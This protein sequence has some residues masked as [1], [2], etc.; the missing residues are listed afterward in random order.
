MITHNIFPTKM[1]EDTIDVEGL[2]GIITSIAKNTPTVSV[3][4]VKG[5]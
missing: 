1:Y 3:S 2:E 4:N 5:Y